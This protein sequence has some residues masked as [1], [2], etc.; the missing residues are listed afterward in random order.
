MFAGN[1][2]RGAKFFFS[3]P[4]FP[5]SFD[6]TSRGNPSLCWFGRGVKRHQECEVPNTIGPIIITLHQVIFLNCSR[7]IF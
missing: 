4:K 3:G 5:P 7:L 6:I 2:G 1:L